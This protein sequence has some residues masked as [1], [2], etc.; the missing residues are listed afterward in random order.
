MIASDH[1]FLALHLLLAQN[2]SIFDNFKIPK[3]S[4]DNFK[5]QNDNKNLLTMMRDNVEIHTKA[6]FNKIVQKIHVFLK[7][8]FL[9]LQKSNFC[10]LEM[11]KQLPILLLICEPSIRSVNPAL[12]SRRDHGKFQKMYPTEK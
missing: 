7:G 11:V 9:K 6:S 8:F 1:K 12:W 10:A 4:F 5:K 2:G 3:T